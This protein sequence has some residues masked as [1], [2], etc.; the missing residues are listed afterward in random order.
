[1]YTEGSYLACRAVGH[2]SQDS[3]GILEH[4]RCKLTADCFR[5]TE[6]SAQVRASMASVAEAAY[7]A[8]MAEDPEAS[9]SLAHTTS[10]HAR[11]LHP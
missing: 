5:H 1:M 11:C 10:L 8:E 2:N 4:Q 7:A 9:S 6:V 3:C